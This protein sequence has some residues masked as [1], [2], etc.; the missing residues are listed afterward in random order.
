MA[1]KRKLDESGGVV[2]ESGSFRV[3]MRLSGRSVK[4][5]RRGNEQRALG[6]LKV[7]RAA[8]ARSANRAE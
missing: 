5:P 2:D 3:R 7:I 8:S 4:G 1:P 6:D